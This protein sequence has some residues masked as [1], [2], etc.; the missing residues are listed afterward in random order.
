[1]KKRIVNIILCL[2]LVGVNANGADY[3]KRSYKW[4][5]NLSLEDGISVT[6]TISFGKDTIINGRSYRLIKNTIPL[7][8]T[9][10]SILM[11]DITAR[12]E[13]LIYNFALQAGDS[14]ELLEDVF[15]G[16][17]RRYAK[18]V[19]TDT[20]VLSNGMKARRIE[21]E[22]TYPRHIDIEYVGDSQRGILGPLDNMFQETLLTR[23]YDGDEVIYVNYQAESLEPIQHIADSTSRLFHNGQIFILRG[24][25][26]YTIQGQEVTLIQ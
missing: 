14:I 3:L 23:F 10:D 9:S 15:D 17:P 18:V 24:D 4:E 16:L 22:Q 1:M 11:Y 26:I 5:V 8:Q 2:V 6:E 21:Y 7:R 12:T 25:K 13:V 19:K 20:I